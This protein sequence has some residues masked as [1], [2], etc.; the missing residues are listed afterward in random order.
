MKMKSFNFSFGLIWLL[1]ALAVA[2]AQQP[3]ILEIAQGDENFST[4]VTAVLATGL[5]QGPLSEDG[6]FS[7]YFINNVG[8]STVSMII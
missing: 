8:F 2:K 5:V 3:S 4:L 7:K 6:P 1:G